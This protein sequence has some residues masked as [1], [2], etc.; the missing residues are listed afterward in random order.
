MNSPA[1]ILAS[2]SPRRK[3]LLDQLGVV[4]SI[5]AQNIDESQKTGESP[6]D[7]VKRLA[8]EKAEAGL[9]QESRNDVLVLGAD[10]IVLC[11]QVVFS[12][13]LDKADAMEMLLM[14]S[15]KAHRVLSAVALVNSSRR[16]SAYS[17]TIVQ[18]RDISQIEAEHY[19]ETGEPKHKAGA[20]AIQGFGA[21]FVKS[22]TG[23]YSGVMGL[24][25]FETAVLLNEFGVCYWRHNQELW[26][27]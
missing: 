18:F 6:K 7:L 1:L 11:D 19:W 21:A 9:K 5:C 12:K 27:E 22:I 15:G 25:L 14:L 20:Y 4:Y 26:N 16:E 2:A 3:Q 10:T 23:S 17:D 24:P 13:P 8:L